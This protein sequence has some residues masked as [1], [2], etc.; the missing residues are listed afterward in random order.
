[1]IYDNSKKSAVLNKIT[2]NPQSV[3]YGVLKSVFP[4]LNF[5][6]G[7]MI[8][9]GICASAFYNNIFFKSFNLQYI[10]II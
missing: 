10:Y 4:H 2:R 3:E 7:E 5:G 9:E 6:F 8:P 1:M